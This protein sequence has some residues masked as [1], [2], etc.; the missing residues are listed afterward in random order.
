MANVRIEFND[1]AAGQLLKSPEVQADLERRARAIAAAAG[2]GEYDITPSMTPT[3]ARVSVGTA[4][5][6]ARHA[7]ATG[8]AL[9]RALD[10]GRG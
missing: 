10:A 8:R 5:H 3:R 4:D 7:E 2:E 9:T 1:T 6:A